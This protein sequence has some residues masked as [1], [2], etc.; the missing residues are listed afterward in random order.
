MLIS[1]FYE[2]KVNKTVSG[3]K[4]SEITVELKISH[5]VT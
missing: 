5:C 1:L 4:I 3:S 2:V